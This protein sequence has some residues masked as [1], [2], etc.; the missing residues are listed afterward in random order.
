MSEPTAER[1][2]FDDRLWGVTT[3]GK[4]G[5]PGNPDALIGWACNQVGRK[6]VSSLPVLS[7]MIANGQEDDAVRML[8]S[9]RWE[10]NKLAIQRGRDLHDAAEMLGLGQP[11][12][13]D[14]ETPYVEQ[15]RRFLEDFAPKFEMVEAPVYNLTYRY[16]GTLDTIAVVQDMRLLWDVKTTDKRPTADNRPPYPETALQLV[17]YRRAE[18]VGLSPALQREWGGRRYYVYDPVAPYAEMPEVDGAAVLVVSPYDYQ[19]VPVRA[20]DEVWQSFLYVR[21]VARWS[22][23]VS[24]RVIGPP[25][26]P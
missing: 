18:L 6:A 20:D 17:A 12:E 25:I 11:L 16:A 1:G 23:D 21:E 4:L 19:L 22:A 10:S 2:D 7:S 15:Y 8:V 5:A 14:R 3:L 26:T 24:K 13:D 9:A